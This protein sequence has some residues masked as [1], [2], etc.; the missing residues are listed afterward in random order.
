MVRDEGGRRRNRGLRERYLAVWEEVLIAY[1][2]SREVVGLVVVEVVVIV[3]ELAVWHLRLLRRATSSSWV[4]C[5]LRGFKKL[6]RVARN[7]L[8]D[9][10]SG[11]RYGR[12]N[13]GIELTEAVAMDRRRL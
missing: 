7:G 13:R 8:I 3:V 6:C 5:A 1:L 10:L 9:Q 12:C 4:V 11:R 2:V